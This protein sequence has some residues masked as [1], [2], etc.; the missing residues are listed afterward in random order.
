MP[1]RGGKGGTPRHNESAP[2]K[3]ERST[4]GGAKHLEDADQGQVDTRKLLGA[5]VSE[6]G[7]VV[8]TGDEYT[9]ISELAY[10]ARKLIAELPAEL[11]AKLRKAL[12]ETKKRTDDELDPLPSDLRKAVRYHYG[13]LLAAHGFTP[14]A[15]EH[16]HART[17]GDR[18]G[19][20]AHAGSGADKTF[21]RISIEDMEKV[22]T[23]IHKMSLNSELFESGRPARHRAAF[24][25]LCKMQY[26]LG[27]NGRL[28]YTE[29]QSHIL[30]E[31]APNSGS[32]LKFRNIQEGF[33]KGKNKAKFTKRFK[34]MRTELIKNKLGHARTASGQHSD[35]RQPKAAPPAQSA[36]RIL[37]RDY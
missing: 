15:R 4:I 28:R 35:R 2:T 26:E 32:K 12:I 22:F 3:G 37:H 25:E 8:Q 17:S 21:P 6:D 27:F 23:S 34:E 9:D 33:E 24:D 36:F 7:R 1:S 5:L 11:V 16:E 14:G 20:V 19:V 29:S 10:D 18:P 31:L 13:E 30:D